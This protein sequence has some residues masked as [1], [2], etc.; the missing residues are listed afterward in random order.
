MLEG[1]V[2]AALIQKRTISLPP[3]L[4]ILCQTILGTMF[5]ILGLILATPLIAMIITAVRLIYVEDMLEI[6][7]AQ[8]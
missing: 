5:G 8:E 2:I 6:K 4:T 3:A 1:N 7:D